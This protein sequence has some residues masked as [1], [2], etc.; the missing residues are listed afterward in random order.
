MYAYVLLQPAAPQ[1]VSEVRKP[2]SHTVATDNLSEATS[3]SIQ[4]SARTTSLSGS[5]EGDKSQLSSSMDGTR[6][7]PSRPLPFSKSKL[8]GPPPP[9]PKPFAATVQQG[10]HNQGT[11]ERHGCSY[12]HCFSDSH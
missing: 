1:K 5:V 3:S 2:R 11:K 10:T 7:L 8:K 9:R 6:P 12:Y 4:D